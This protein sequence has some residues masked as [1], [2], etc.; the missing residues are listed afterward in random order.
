MHVTMEYKIRT[1]SHDGAVN[2]LAPTTCGFVYGVNVQYPSVEAAIMNKYAGDRIEVYLPPEELF[3]AYDESLVRELPLSD[4][5]PERIRPGQVY[6]E[7]RKQ[8]LVQFLVR[9]VRGDIV[10]A[11]FNDPR[12]GSSATFEI[13]IR[14][15]REASREEMKPSCAP[16]G[17]S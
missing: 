11:D 16:A 14:D 7:M 17:S 1:T 13:L 3:G 15:V 12:A 10:I 9:E 8:C 5:K 4:Y 2:E 6:R